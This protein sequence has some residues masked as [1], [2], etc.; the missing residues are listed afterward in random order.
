MLFYANKMTNNKPQSHKK[1]LVFNV[2]PNLNDLSWRSLSENDCGVS[3]M[4]YPLTTNYI[5][6]G[7]MFMYL[8]EY[9]GWLSANCGHREKVSQLYM[10]FW[11]SRVSMKTKHIFI[12]CGFNNRIFDLF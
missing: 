10:P 7:Y 1:T 3:A 8:P 6:D 12:I 11:S 9:V 2:W 5:S 4:L